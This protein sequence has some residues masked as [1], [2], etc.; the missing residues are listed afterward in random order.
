MNKMQKLL[1]MVAVVAVLSG[2]AIAADTSS[3]TA[4]SKAP[5]LSGSAPLLGFKHQVVAAAG[6]SAGAFTFDVPAPKGT[7]SIIGCM[8]TA[9]DVSGSVKRLNMSRSGRTVTVGNSNATSGTVATGDFVRAL[10][11]YDQQ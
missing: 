7:N 10:C 5:E 2:A 9:Y 3:T 11:V 8:L 4:R 6:V 1:G